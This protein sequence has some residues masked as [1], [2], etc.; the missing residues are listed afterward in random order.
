MRGGGAEGLRSR[1]QIGFRLSLKRGCIV[2]FVKRSDSLFQ[3]AS[4]ALRNNL[5]PE[6]FFILFSPIQ[7]V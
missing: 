2:R 1:K 5:A 3:R 6:Q 7:N 4:A